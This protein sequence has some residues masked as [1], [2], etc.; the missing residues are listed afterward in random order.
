VVETLARAANASQ[1]RPK[2]KPGVVY[3]RTKGEFGEGTL[4]S[5]RLTPCEGN[6]PVEVTL[7][8]ESVVLLLLEGLEVSA[9]LSFDI[10]VLLVE[11]LIVVVS[12]CMRRVSIGIVLWLTVRS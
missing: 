12:R 11:Y 3:S 7:I 5:Q 9:A 8:L 10:V 1:A 6:K 4:V 2:S